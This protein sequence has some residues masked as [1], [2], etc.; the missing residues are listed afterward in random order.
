MLDL[1]FAWLLGH[2]PVSSVIAG[3]NQAGTGEGQRRRGRLG[4]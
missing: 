3:A 1:A 2:P 4:G